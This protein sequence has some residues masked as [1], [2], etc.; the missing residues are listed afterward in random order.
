MRLRADRLRLLFGDGFDA[1]RADGVLKFCNASL[2]PAGGA[3]TGTVVD[4]VM[5]GAGPGAIVAAV[6]CPAT[7]LLSKLLVVTPPVLLLCW[8]V[9]SGD[10]ALIAYSSP[11]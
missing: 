11:I 4:D 6:Y 7:R 2:A 5:S 1:T 8:G 10:R 9:L 3:A